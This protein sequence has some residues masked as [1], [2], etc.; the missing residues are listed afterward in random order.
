MEDSCAE[1]WF[2]ENEEGK[3]SGVKWSGLLRPNVVKY[4][5]PCERAGAQIF[6]PD[7]GGEGSFYTPASWGE[8]VK[9]T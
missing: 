9:F 7:E 6:R 5:G 2:E 4:V 1:G 3:G 8:G